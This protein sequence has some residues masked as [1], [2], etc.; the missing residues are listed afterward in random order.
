MNRVT[1]VGSQVGQ[2]SRQPGRSARLQGACS[3]ASSGAGARQKLLGWYGALSAA[4]PPKRSPP[5]CTAAA[6]NCRAHTAHTHRR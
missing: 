1:L 4:L 5:I 3:G 6:P 2:E